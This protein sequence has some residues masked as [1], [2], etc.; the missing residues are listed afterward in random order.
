M[1]F[2][3]NSARIAADF[4]DFISYEREQNA[5]Y[6]F[7]AQYQKSN[8]QIGASFS[9]NQDE[10]SVIDTPDDSLQI[11][12]YPTHGFELFFQYFPN[13]SLGASSRI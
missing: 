5:N 7:A 1:G 3:F 9:I 13:R 11:V 4:N 2:A 8:I 10:F 6:V 12:A